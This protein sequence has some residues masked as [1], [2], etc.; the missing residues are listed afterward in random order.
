MLTHDAVM[1]QYVS[2]VVDASIASDDL[3]LHAL[4]LYHCAQL[5]VFFGPAIY[6]GASN[7]ITGQPVAEHLLA[8]I[9]AA[10][11][12]QLL[13]AAHGVDRAAA[14]A[15]LRRHRPVAA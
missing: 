1:W 12:Q 15:G 8:L 11:H 2:C 3:M 6:V 9:A 4:P 10:P 14:F 7:V 5:D 13:R